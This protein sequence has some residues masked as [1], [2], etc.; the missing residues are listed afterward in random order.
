VAMIALQSADAQAPVEPIY[1]GEP[2]QPLTP[3]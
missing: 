2:V 3:G 1:L